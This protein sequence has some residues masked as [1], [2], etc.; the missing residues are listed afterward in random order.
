MATAL[1]PIP[2]ADYRRAPCALVCASAY[3]IAEGRP[4]TEQ[5]AYDLSTS[6]VR[7][8]GM[9]RAA[10]GDEVSVRLQLPREW[11][12]TRG[13][14]V[15]VASTVEK[16]N[17]AIEFCDLSADAEDAIHDA[18]VDALAHPNRR[19]LL[20]L[21]Q[22]EVPHRPACFEWLDPVSAL[23]ATARTPLQAVVGLEQQR[24]DIGIFGSG[25][26]GTQNSHWTEMYP[27]V[28][29]RSIDCEGRLH[30][31]LTKPG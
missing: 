28:C 24:F 10:I 7:L 12:G 22:E 9:P 17:F 31:V 2:Q 15:R 20:L 19:S 6:G 29:W 30:P 1:I 26:C 13:H 11:V 16:P 25:Y 23:C 21:Q 14:L 3:V 4:A 8:C 27:E 5:L 18:V